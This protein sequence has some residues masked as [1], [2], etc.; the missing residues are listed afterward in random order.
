MDGLHPQDSQ[1]HLAARRRRLLL[2]DLARADRPEVTLLVDRLGPS[3]NRVAFAKHL[4]LHCERRGSASNTVAEKSRTRKRTGP[5]RLFHE[6]IRAPVVVHPGF[7][8]FCD[9]R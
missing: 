2:L 3:E 9:E 4:T 8:E 1:N 5:N 7:D 6:L